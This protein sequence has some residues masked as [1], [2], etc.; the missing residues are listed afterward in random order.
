V[1]LCVSA[2][3]EI[4]LGQLA[5]VTVC[6]LEMHCVSGCVATAT[7]VLNYSVLCAQSVLCD[8]CPQKS[9]RKIVCT[10]CAR[11]VLCDVALH[12]LLVCVRLALA[13]RLAVRRTTY[14]AR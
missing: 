4:P 14:L 5:T 12:E 3:S 9:R 10:T 6:V 7:A 2:Y 8:V 1:C 11:Y 13:R